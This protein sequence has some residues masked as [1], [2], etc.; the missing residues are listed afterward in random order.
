MYIQHIAQPVV[1]YDGETHLSF[2]PSQR[3]TLIPC[4]HSNEEMF[5][6]KLFLLL[7]L[8]AE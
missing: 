2:D 5:K 6:R 8:N 4:V 1:K 7:S 3:H